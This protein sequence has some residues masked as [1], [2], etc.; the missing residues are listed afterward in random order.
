MN[1]T[2]KQCFSWNPTVTTSSLLY[3]EEISVLLG[4]LSELM[5]ERLGS[6]TKGDFILMGQRQE[7]A[8]IEIA[9]CIMDAGHGASTYLGQ[10]CSTEDLAQRAVNCVFAFPH[11]GYNTTADDLFK[12]WP[13]A[14]IYEDCTGLR[15]LVLNCSNGRFLASCYADFTEPHSYASTEALITTALTLCNLRPHDRKL[16]TS[17]GQIWDS[18]DA[19][20]TDSV[21]DVSNWA[22][23]AFYGS[24]TAPMQDWRRWRKKLDKVAELPTYFSELNCAI[25]T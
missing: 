22:T 15:A 24:Q 8:S 18:L 16:R 10:S 12:K 17:C 1:K 20:V 9:R 4:I 5:S 19:E 3:E 7:G 2:K 21:A 13:T 11:H 6:P 25:A 23:E 14:G